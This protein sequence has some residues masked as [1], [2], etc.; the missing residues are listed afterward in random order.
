MCS[1]YH[2]WCSRWDLG[3]ELVQSRP[4]EPAARLS[5]PTK[6]HSAGFAS[7]RKGDGRGWI[8]LRAGTVSGRDARPRLARDA[9]RPITITRPGGPHLDVREHSLCY[10]DTLAQPVLEHFVTLAFL[11]VPG[12]CRSDHLR[13]WHA[14]NSS[15]GVQILGLVGGQADGHS[16]AQIHALRICR[17]VAVVKFGGMSV[18]W[19]RDTDLI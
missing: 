12:D 4:V 11:D 14:V 19:Y 2:T 17:G 8:R 5:V 18:L 7:V 13:D 16:L 1:C 9:R 15:D 6:A 10:L 3:R